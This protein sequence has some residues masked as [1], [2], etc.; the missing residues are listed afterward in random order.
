MIPFDDVIMNRNGKFWRETSYVLT[1]STQSTCWCFSLW[2]CAGQFYPYPSGLLYYM[3]PGAEL[4]TQHQPPCPQQND[5]KS[6]LQQTRQHRVRH[7]VIAQTWLCNHK[8]MHTVPVLASLH[9]RHNERECVS[10][11]QS[12]DCL[13]NRLFRRR[14]KKTSKLRVS[15]LCA[16]NSPGPMNSPHKWPVTRKMLPF[17]DVFM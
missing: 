16:G 8:I 2:F 9:W 15:G 3:S 12:H 10:N 14:S 11:H 7:K 13:L 17:D 5:W 1:I 6:H 4:L